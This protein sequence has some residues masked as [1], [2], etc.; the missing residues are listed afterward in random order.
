MLK[1][2]ALIA[3]IDNCYGIGRNNNLL[4]DIPND[5]KHFKK[6]TTGYPI[7]M[8]KN[9]YKSLPNSKPLPNRENI[10]ISSSIDTV[11]NEN[12]NQFKWFSNI[13]LA[14]KYVEENP[15]NEK[16]FFIGGGKIYESIL[17]MG[18]ITDM[19]ITHIDSNSFA[20]TFFPQFNIE[21]WDVVSTEEH[22]DEYYDFE[23][24]FIHYRKKK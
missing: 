24:H 21:E 23:Y 18:I 12:F 22:I 17:E 6:I 14:L 16:V 19:Y 15:N 11:E 20:D 8:G 2:I 10:V 5:L 3:A 9:T 1:E 4:Y 7:I 13:K